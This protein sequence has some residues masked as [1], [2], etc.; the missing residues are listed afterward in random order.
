MDNRINL[1][2]LMEARV[3]I[4]L[5]FFFF[6]FLN[7]FRGCIHVYGGLDRKLSPLGYLLFHNSFCRLSASSIAHHANRTVKIF[8]FFFYIYGFYFEHFTRMQRDTINHRKYRK[9]LQAKKNL[10][11][12]IDIEQTP[13]YA[14]YEPEN[15]SKHL[16][17]GSL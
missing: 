2:H 6:F 9:F 17:R 1:G 4:L 12:C 3:S 13:I 14:L 8:I 7:S 15:R 10:S 5:P 11:S 16:L